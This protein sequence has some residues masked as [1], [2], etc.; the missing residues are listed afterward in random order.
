[1]VI[2][3]FVVLMFS[4]LMVYIANTTNTALHDTLDNN[5]AI[6]QLLQKSGQNTSQ[7]IE[8]TFGRVPTSYAHL[9][10]ITVM[11]ILGMV[12]G[13]FYGSYKVRTEPIYFLPYTLVTGV[14]IL[15]SAGLANAYE[16]IMQNDTLAGTFA[17]FVGGNHF[18]LNL[19][20]YMGIIGIIG[21]IILFISWATKPASDGGYSY[22]GN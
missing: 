4:V 1:M 16:T 5:P 15:V 22:Y 3:T 2:V 7:I 11:L 8:N 10:W 6:N 13:I 12:V 18:F 19:P 17:G 20:L 9:H 14:V 21:G